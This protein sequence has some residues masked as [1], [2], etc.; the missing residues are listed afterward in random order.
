MSKLSDVF[1]ALC[2]T[3]QAEVWARFQSMLKLLLW[4]EGAEWGKGNVYIS[5]HDIRDGQVT[6]CCYCNTMISVVVLSCWQANEE[7]SQCI[8]LS[9]V[10]L[11]KHSSDGGLSKD[12]SHTDAYFFSRRDIK[13]IFSSTY[14][15]EFNRAWIFAS[16]IQW[17]LWF[18]SW[19]GV[20]ESELWTFIENHP[21]FRI[22]NSLASVVLGCTNKCTRNQFPTFTISLLATDLFHWSFF[23][24]DD[25]CIIQ[26]RAVH[27]AHWNAPLFPKSNLNIGWNGMLFFQGI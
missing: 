1:F 24:W 7:A 13:G 12:G 27:N 10:M 18:W 23:L 17:K 9:V 26:H 25:F 22:E 4:T 21:K 16:F 11:C 3:N 5:N 20:V 8:V 14:S 19:I 2:Q 6:V 15:I